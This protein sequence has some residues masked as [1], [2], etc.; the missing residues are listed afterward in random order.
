M[1]KSIIKEYNDTLK[2]IFYEGIKTDSTYAV[3]DKTVKFDLSPLCI[4]N[5]KNLYEYTLMMPAT[6][7]SR[8]SATKY[9]LAEAIWYR[10]ATRKIDLIEEFGPIW[11]KMADSHGKVNSN[12]GYQITHNQNVKEIIAA[13]PHTRYE[14]FM[15][16]S[17][18]NMTSTNDLVCNN[19]VDVHLYQLNDEY[20]LDARVVARSIDMIMG[21]PYDMFAAQGFLAMIATSVQK[22]IK[23]PVRLGSLAFIVSNLHWYFSHN[24]SEE[25][26]SSLLDDIRI[27]N[28]ENTPF[29][30]HSYL[31]ITTPDK[32]REYRDKEA[33]HA[34][35]DRR[36]SEIDHDDT[37]ANVTR[38]V[39]KYDDLECA[40][41]ALEQE[42]V[43]LHVSKKEKS[44]LQSHLNEIILRLTQNQF[45]RKTM[46]VSGQN[47][48]YIMFDG[49]KYVV[50][51]DLV[52]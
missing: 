24:P 30:G 25:E 29:H 32:I 42:I 52:N 2:E 8:K 22:A 12:Y 45:E 37:F 11:K 17:E 40:K 13:L 31:N 15:I 51:V 27:I 47:V 14:S 26:L 7:G 28:Y 43:S 38:K 41:F 33:L 36:E 23:H 34:R 4:R 44:R 21:L 3:I 35:L 46:L 19:R 49:E 48:Y 50:I 10:H 20:I 9:A 16:A 1:T 18:E 5:H 6:R 39:E